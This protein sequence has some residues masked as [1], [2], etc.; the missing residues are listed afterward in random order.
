[1]AQ[2]VEFEPQYHQKE[3][4]F[5]DFKLEGSHELA[6]DESKHDSFK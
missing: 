5:S 1:M 6:D 2:V 3:R 4:N